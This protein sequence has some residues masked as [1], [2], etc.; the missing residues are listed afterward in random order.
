MF[1]QAYVLREFLLRGLYLGLNIG[2]D[3]ITKLVYVLG[4]PLAHV[5]PFMGKHKKAVLEN[6]NSR[7][8]GKEMTK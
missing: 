8:I 3:I 4:I 7:N 1:P 5:N 2:C 6:T